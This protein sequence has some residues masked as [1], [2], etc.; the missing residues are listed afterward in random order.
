MHMAGVRE[1]AS[2]HS[3]IYMRMRMHI[4]MLMRTHAHMHLLAHALDKY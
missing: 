2:M 4:Y 3:N 1:K